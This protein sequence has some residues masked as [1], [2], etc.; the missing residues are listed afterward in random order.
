MTKFIE[1][2]CLIAIIMLG[3]QLYTTANETKAT[4]NREILKME[5]QQH[6]DELMHLY[7]QQP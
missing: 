7:R 5:A 2:I 3:M 6:V 1:F 4:I